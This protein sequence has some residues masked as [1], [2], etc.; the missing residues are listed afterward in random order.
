MISNDYVDILKNK[1]SERCQRNKEY[2]LRA[3]AR[4]LGI[5]PQRLSHILNRNY[6]LSEKAATDIAKKLGFTEN[7]IT[8]FTTMVAAKHSRS[9]IAKDKAS[10]QLAE[11]K[12]HYQDLSIDHFKIVSDWYHFAIMELS[13]LESFSSSPKSVAKALDITELEAKIAIER[14]LRLELM[15]KTKGGKL[16][17]TGNYFADPKGTPSDALKKFHQQLMQ[18]AQTALFT[19][20]LAEREFSSTII[21]INKSDLAEAQKD[22]R[23]FRASFDKKFSVK[24]NKTNIYCLGMQFFRIDNIQ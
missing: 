12:S 15:E 14:L 17:I 7:E 23:A 13:L 18:K 21:A 4:D 11:L 2:S 8:H 10:K 16:K 20:G 9:K 1:F 6:G 24:D 19:Q 22:L 5:S 3:Y